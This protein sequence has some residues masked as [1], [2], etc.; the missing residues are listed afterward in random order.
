VAQGGREEQFLKAEFILKGK[1]GE[2]EEI[3]TLYHILT[4]ERSEGDTRGCVVAEW[5]DT[6]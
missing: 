6:C 2:R 3:L 1:I 5:R 4:E